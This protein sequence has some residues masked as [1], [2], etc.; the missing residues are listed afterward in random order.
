[1]PISNPVTRMK[2]ASADY[3]RLLAKYKELELPSTKQHSD[4]EQYEESARGENSDA[5]HCQG[6]VLGW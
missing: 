1:V 4:E 6:V 3:F 2:T 5:D